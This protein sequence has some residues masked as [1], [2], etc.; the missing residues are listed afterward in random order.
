MTR[1]VVL[2]LAAVA[3]LPLAGSGQEPRQTFRSGT[4]A[5]RVDVS[6]QDGRRPIAGLTPDD[7]EV[8]DNGV[9]QQVTGISYGRLPIDVTVVLDTSLSVNGAT[10]RQLSQATRQL[11]ADL[12]PE[13]RLKLVGF[14]MRVS[15][16]VDF[17]SATTEVERAIAQSTASG[18]SSIRDAASVALISASDPDRRQLVV[19]FTDG[20]DSS[21]T[22][23]EDALL[24]VAR[25][26]NAALTVVI[27]ERL[28]AFYSSASLRRY[29]R[30]LEGLTSETGGSVLTAGGN[31]TSTFR[32]ALDEF[33]SSYVLYFTPDGVEGDAFHTLEVKV[34]NRRNA[35]VRARRG[36][37]AGQTAEGKG[38]R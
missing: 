27:P 31:M 14:N 32:R 23:S 30:W 17:T 4:D 5:V 2:M 11:M 3:A 26:T 10:M 29:L 28:R 37:F 1:R 33:R 36:Y 12:T 8:Y 18:G 16:V 34:A 35:T 19:L 13:D 38:Q 24:E 9:R 22:T 7:F 25:R 6:V 20:A 15:R 21:S